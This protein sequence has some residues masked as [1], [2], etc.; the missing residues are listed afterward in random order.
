MLLS[1]QNQ[2]VF[3]FLH[4][5]LP[6]K[7]REINLRGKHAL[8]ILTLEPV[9]YLRNFGAGYF[10]RVHPDVFFIILTV[11]TNN[12]AVARNCVAEA[13]TVEMLALGSR[14]DV[15]YANMASEIFL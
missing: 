9:L 15:L 3:P 2:V 7:G 5:F 8:S 6:T 13:L 10:V 12:M 14:C 11:V 4:T 1:F